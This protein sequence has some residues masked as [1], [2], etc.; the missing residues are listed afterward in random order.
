MSEWIEVTLG[1][2]IDVKHGFA[3]EGF[4]IHDYPQG[5]VLLTPGNFSIGGGFKEGKLKY[6]D[7]PVPEEVRNS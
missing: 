4:Y 3:F 5:D 6:Y 7:G 2:I 1:D